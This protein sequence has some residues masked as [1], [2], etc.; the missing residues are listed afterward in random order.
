MRAK[1]AAKSMFGT[2]IMTAISARK[3][4]NTM[5]HF[6]RAEG[7]AGFGFKFPIFASTG[8]PKKMTRNVTEAGSQIVSGPPPKGGNSEWERTDEM[9]Q[10]TRAGMRAVAARALSISHFM[11]APLDDFWCSRL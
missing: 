9:K 10:I 1:C 11:P 6:S 4:N 3:I 7:L 8:I 2:T 5:K